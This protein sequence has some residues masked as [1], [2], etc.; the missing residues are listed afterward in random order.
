MAAVS[1]LG[2]LEQ[3]DALDVVASKRGIRLHRFSW[4]RSVV[5]RCIRSGQFGTRSGTP[6]TLPRGEGVRGHARTVH[7]FMASLW[8][9]SDFS[10]FPSVDSD[11]VVEQL[12]W[13]DLEA[14]RDAQDGCEARLAGPALK[15]TDRRGVDVGRVGEAIL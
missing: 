1:Q 7:D 10:E 3:R 11:E 4:L 14:L 13:R 6:S 15:T 5:F 12:A 9:A 2:A 8:A